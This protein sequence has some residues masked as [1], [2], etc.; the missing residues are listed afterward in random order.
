MTIAG[1]RFIARYCVRTCAVL[2]APMPVMAS[3]AP[4]DL[5]SVASSGVAA[6]TRTPRTPSSRA[7]LDVV[8]LRGDGVRAHD[9][10][11]DDG[12]AEERDDGRRGGAEVDADAD[13]RLRRRIGVAAF[14]NRRRLRLAARA[15]RD[16]SRQH[17]PRD[18]HDADREQAD[19]EERMPGVL[20]RDEAE[21]REDDG[22]GAEPGRPQRRKA[23]HAGERRVAEADPG[24]ERTAN[25]D[26]AGDERDVI[27]THATA[28]L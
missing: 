27:A 22:E 4:D 13:E 20:S 7:T 2:T 21:R 16:R 12:E 17:A 24:K 23:R 1:A 28:R 15:I 11:D 26:E 9:P 18:D 6:I 10:L 3:A 25:Q 8:V 19:H 5:I 14:D